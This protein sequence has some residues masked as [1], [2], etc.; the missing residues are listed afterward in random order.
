MSAA[1]YHVERGNRGGA[2]RLFTASRE[3]LESVKEVGLMLDR[4][5]IINFL[6]RAEERPE[7]IEIPR[8]PLLTKAFTNRPPGWCTKD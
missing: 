4:E 8:L 3:K 1:L 6:A 2:A 5:A 7:N